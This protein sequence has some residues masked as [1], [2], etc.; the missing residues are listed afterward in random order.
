M[1]SKEVAQM[2]LDSFRQCFPLTVK[3]QQR[4]NED[5]PTV[6]TLAY[7]IRFDDD[8]HD[9]RRQKETARATNRAGW[10]LVMSK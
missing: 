7:G 6:P 1:P 5:F 2:M 3:N 9:K 10:C 4:Q 8:Y